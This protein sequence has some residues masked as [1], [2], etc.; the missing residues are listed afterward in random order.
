LSGLILTEVGVINQYFSIKGKSM[1]P[2]FWFVCRWTI[3]VAAV[4]TGYAAPI[5][6]TGT[7]NVG[8]DI[9][10]LFFSGPGLSFAA[11]VTFENGPILFRTCGNFATTP[12]DLSVSIPLIGDQIGSVQTILATFNGETLTNQFG[13]PG[14]ADCGTATGIVTFSTAPILF[15]PNPTAGPIT[16]PTT[17]SGEVKAVFN[18]GQQLFDLTVSGSGT[19]SS[20]FEVAGNTL[21]FDVGFN[22]FSGTADPIPEPGTGALLA[23]SLLAAAGCRLARRAVARFRS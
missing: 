23:S 18:N 9:L 6:I 19:L 14:G 2:P 4:S 1:R 11:D 12:C 15:G 17:V 21:V 13:C 3:I 8:S 16:V 7:S 10:N 22:S 20:G 5:G